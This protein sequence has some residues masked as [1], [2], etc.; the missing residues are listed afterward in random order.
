[1]EQVVQVAQVQLILQQVVLILYFLLLHQLAVDMAQA[2]LY[3][4][5]AQQA[6]Q[7]V[8][9]VTMLLLVVVLLTKVLQVVQVQQEIP[10]KAAAV[11]VLAQ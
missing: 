7:A 1:L 11:V 3:R 4:E 8:V 2:P 6:V 10:I 9:L 5:L